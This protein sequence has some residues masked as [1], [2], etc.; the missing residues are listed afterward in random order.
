MSLFPKV[1]IVYLSYHSE[2][3]LD[4]VV[5]SLKRLIYPKDRVEFVVVDN[6]HPEFGSSARAIEDKLARISG[7]EIPRVTVL[8]Q[9]KNLGF[10]G[11]NNQGVKWALDH[12]FDY[13]YF[14]NNDGF[15]DANC[16]EPLV[17]AMEADKS[18]GLAQSLLLLYPETEFINTS[19][20]VFHYLGFGYCDNYRTP[21]RDFNGPPVREINYAS[22]AG[23]MV[24][25][26]TARALGVWDSDFFLYHEDLEW[27]LRLRMAGYR[28]VMVKDSIFYHKY[29]FSR[30]IQ[31][32]YWMERNRFAVLL[33]F[34]R[35]PT[36]IFLLPMLLVLEAGLWLFAIKHGWMNERVKLYKY[37]LNP[38]HWPLWL[39]K[40]R[41]IQ[42]I[43]KVSDREILKSAS[44]TIEFQEK[45]M[46]NPVLT[47]IGNPLMR[48]YYQIIMIFIRW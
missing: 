44:P 47:K 31:K 3:Y 1:A 36:L 12:D 16:L 38:K 46:D 15:M 45:S 25:S 34:F 27:S 20:N 35:L 18:I 32:F 10:A 37:W 5:A 2:P 30:S 8:A 9:E 26:A 13:V 29:Q 48:L 24:S 21:F 22:G 4:D 43:R 33:M 41:H 17:N 14:H 19:G 40:R 39:G 6:L 28:V 11:G 7:K 42:S 23:A